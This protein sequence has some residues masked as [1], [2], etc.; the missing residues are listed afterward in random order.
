MATK[1]FIKKD[2]KG[3]SYIVEREMT[4]SEEIKEWYENNPYKDGLEQSGFHVLLFPIIVGII[5]IFCG[6][7]WGWGIAL[8]VG[9]CYGFCFKNEDL[10]YG[11]GALVTLGW[12][13][14]G[15][16]HLFKWFAES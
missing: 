11:I 14:F 16:Y 6:N 3:N 10:G 2:R 9:L 1:K 13:L 8:S 4:P 7:A 12:I 5:M 15:I